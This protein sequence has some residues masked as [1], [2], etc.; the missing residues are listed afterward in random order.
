MVTYV[1][2]LNIIYSNSQRQSSERQIKHICDLGA[3]F[4]RSRVQANIQT[5]ATKVTNMLYLSFRG[6]LPL[7]VANIIYSAEPLLPKQQSHLPSMPAE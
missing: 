1:S 2:I 4:E 7:P 5:A 6:H 3:R